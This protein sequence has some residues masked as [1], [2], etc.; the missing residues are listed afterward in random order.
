MKIPNFIVC[1]STLSFFQLPCK[2]KYN[3]KHKSDPTCMK[4]YDILS[5]T[6]RIYRT[7]IIIDFFR[8]I[9]SGWK[10][11]SSR[12]SLLPTSL[13]LGHLFSTQN[14]HFPLKKGVLGYWD[15]F[16]PFTQP[17]YVMGICGEELCDL[18]R[19]RKT[20]TY[21]NPLFLLLPCSLSWK[22]R[23]VKR[24]DSFLVVRV[25]LLFLPSILSANSGASV[26]CAE[27]PHSNFVYASSFFTPPHGK[28]RGNPS[29]DRRGVHLLN[30]AVI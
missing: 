11:G 30:Y 21:M 1:R 9:F 6:T 26:T 8:T 2:I 13:T 24:T 12:F 29:N 20:N 4:S 3:V 14:I 25:I 10:S 7:I 23:S 27:C 15:D 16:S 5:Q 28:R 22:L 17:W 19:L 18:S